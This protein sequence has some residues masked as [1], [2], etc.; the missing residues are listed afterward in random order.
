MSGRSVLV[1][2]FCVGAALLSCSGV[3]SA[4]GGEPAGPRDETEPTGGADEERARARTLANEGLTAY[5]RGDYSTA[6]A[7]F[8][9]AE[10]IVTAPTI[11]LH[12]ARCLEKL[13][14]LAEAL[15]HYGTIASTPIP[16]DAPYVHHR[17]KQDALLEQQ[18]LEPRVPSLA[19]EVEGE[20]GAGAELVVDGRGAPFRAD[21]APR[22]LDPGPHTIEVRRKD[23]TKAAV[24]IQLVER[25]QERVRLVL[26]P[27]RPGGE[28][29]D[30]TEGDE[31]GDGAGLFGLDGDTQRTAGWV[32]VATGGV[33]L[34]VALITGGAAIVIGS[35]LDARCP[36]GA[37]PRDA[38]GDVDQHDGYRAASTVGW[39]VA[40]A[41]GAAGVALL[42]TAPDDEP[43]AT[44]RAVVGPNGVHLRVDY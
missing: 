24:A 18:A 31:A 36:D 35:D 44:A 40:G 11:A 2:A 28:S 16:S 9:Q 29:G 1:A 43:D 12:H 20:P 5:R 30:G 19:V 4:Q 37:C 34:S 25:R 6:L 21:D 23:G 39:I 3:A 26:P 42:L 7:K 32:A 27:P 8:E 22:R 10:R 13:G 15:A 17:A 14:R 38:W 41:F 33:G